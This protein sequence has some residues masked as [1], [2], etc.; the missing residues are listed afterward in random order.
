MNH[1]LIEILGTGMFWNTTFMST[2]KE[3]KDYVSWLSDG[4]II[5]GI[6][7]RDSCY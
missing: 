5:A 7:L 6:L 1:L 3:I 2:V 4:D